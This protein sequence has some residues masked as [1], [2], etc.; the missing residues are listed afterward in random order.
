MDALAILVSGGLDSA[1]LLGEALR[2]GSRV[3]P[4]Y[5]RCGLFWE[6]VEVAY[7]NRYLR[8]VQS[9][10]LEPLTVLAQPVA[11]LYGDHW[12]IT[13]RGVP[14]ASSA[15]DAVYLPGR[16][17]LLLTKAL[18]WCHL[19]NIPSLAVG[20]LGSNPFPDASL[21]FFRDIATVVNQGVQGNV[22]VLLP[23]AEMIK[24]AVMRLGMG[25]PLEH[26]FSCINPTSDRHCGKCNK[27]AERRQAFVSAGMLDP[28]HYK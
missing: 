26:S 11:D 4:I 6:H 14:D 20:S 5:V 17:L 13:G 8:A 25:L 16:N 15:D 28:T 22:R 1:I 19:H 27:C 10:L 24:S 12:S 23:F 3:Y 2:Q 18:L 7:V 9:P 21:S